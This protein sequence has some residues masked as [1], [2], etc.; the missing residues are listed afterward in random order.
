MHP[1]RDLQLQ[2]L[3]LLVGAAAGAYCSRSAPLQLLHA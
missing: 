3:V 2:L 1:V